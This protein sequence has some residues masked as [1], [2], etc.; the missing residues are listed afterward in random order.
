MKKYIGILSAFLSIVPVLSA[1][2]NDVAITHIA[3]VSAV[4]HGKQKTI[5]STIDTKKQENKIA[6]TVTKLKT[7]DIEVVSQKFKVGKMPFSSS[8]TFTIPYSASVKS[9]DAVYSID[10]VPVNYKI[11]F[12]KAVG[13]VNG[14][15]SNK[16][17][18]FI[19]EVIGMGKKLVME[20]SFSTIMN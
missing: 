9:P 20:I 4:Y 19:V 3:D 7:G 13:S 17:G 11:A 5:F 6:I 12:S 15:M 2:A 14:T 18:T 10:N 1:R 16:S 8:F